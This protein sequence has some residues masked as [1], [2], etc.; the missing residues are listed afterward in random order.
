VATLA[1]TRHLLLVLIDAAV[2]A[3]WSAVCGYAA[4]RLS[5][6]RLTE[7]RWLR[8]RAV[9]RDGRVYER[10]LRIKAWK[11]LL[12]EA[13]SLFRGGF[14]KRRIT[15]HDPAYLERFARE[16]VRAERTHWAILALS[17]VFYLWNPW[18]LAT[19]MLGY[20][21][22]ANVPCLLVQRYNRAR[23]ERILRVPRRAAGRA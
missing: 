5:D 21:V 3:A 19:A 4:H 14:S 16:T 18:W 23:L 9:E 22:L 20:G 2:W 8:L 10:V 17:P 6:G 12:P 13:G 7:P 1:S 15:R 11:D